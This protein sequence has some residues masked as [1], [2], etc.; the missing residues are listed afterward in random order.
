VSCLAH[1]RARRGCSPAARV[2]LLLLLCGTAG[3]ARAATFAGL[4]A[5]VEYD[6]NASRA[7]FDFD[8]ESDVFFSV[9][10][11]GGWHGQ[12]SRN[13]GVTVA[14][15]LE[16]VL[17]GEAERL[18]RVT[19]SLAVAWRAKTR[20]GADAPWIELRLAGEYQDYRSTIRRG[21][22][23]DGRATWGQSV[24]TRW[25]YRV[26]AGYSR[27]NADAEAFDQ[28]G[29]TLGASAEF[30]VRPATRL[31]GGY[32]FRRGDVTS[33]ATPGLVDPRT[34]PI[35]A[36]STARVAD[37]AFAGKIAYRL[38]ADTHAVHVGVHRAVGT[39]GAVDLRYEHQSIRAAAGLE[40]RVNLVRGSYAHR[41]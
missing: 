1:E 18:G 3:P 14:A 31:F 38:D 20:F 10:P 13:T 32:E 19:P 7:V 23:V 12:V 21:T 17:A 37:D 11:S 2:V 15:A 33:T 36:N 24:G 8:V 34:A 25:S 41:F 27:R 40:Y 6:D 22:L 35:L 26:E 39:R 5:G 9:R 28:D 16:A 4:E 29:T 30:A